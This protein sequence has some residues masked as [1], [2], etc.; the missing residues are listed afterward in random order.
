MILDI[1]EFLA[2]TTTKYQTSPKIFDSDK[3][4][5][6]VVLSASGKKKCLMLSTSMGNNDRCS[7]VAMEL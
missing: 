1:V 5:S 6:L 4:L 7:K 2:F 3:R